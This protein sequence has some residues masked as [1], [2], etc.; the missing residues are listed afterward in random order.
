MLGKFCKRQSCSPAIL[1]IVAVDAE[2]LLEYLNCSFTES[3]C[4]WVVGSGEPE[5]DI[6]L[7]VPLLL[8][9]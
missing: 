2:V 9:F 1:P 4:L 8:E 6:E 7:L 3:I 5:M